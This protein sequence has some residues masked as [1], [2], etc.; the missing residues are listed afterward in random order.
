MVVASGQQYDGGEKPT[1]KLYALLL[2]QSPC[3]DT[4]TEAKRDDEPGYSSIFLHWVW[5]RMGVNT[6]VLYYI[7]GPTILLA[8]KQITITVTVT[9]TD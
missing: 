5:D 2:D 1:I 4:R 3:R 7:R 9:V 6:L 8:I